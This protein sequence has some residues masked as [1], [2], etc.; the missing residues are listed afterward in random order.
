MPP[1]GDAYDLMLSSSMTLLSAPAALMISL[2]SSTIASV[3][4][5]LARMLAWLM[6]NMMSAAYF[7]LMM[8]WKASVARAGLTVA[9]SAMAA[10]AITPSATFTRGRTYC[11]LPWVTV[12][13]SSSSLF[14]ISGLYSNFA[15]M[16]KV[17]PYS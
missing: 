14:D 8:R 3:L 15:G 10:V 16:L 13:A 2:R 5:W 4:S 9:A 1:S 6:R 7:S 12:K 17:P 11:L